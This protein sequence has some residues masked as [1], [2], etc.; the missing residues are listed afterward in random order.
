[1]IKHQIKGRNNKYIVELYWG[2]EGWLPK[3]SD[4][5]MH[6]IWTFMK[7]YNERFIQLVED[8]YGID[9]EN[10]PLETILRFYIDTGLFV[11]KGQ[12]NDYALRRMKV[13]AKHYRDEMTNE[14]YQIT[15][16]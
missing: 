1:M 12:I 10:D 15:G 8:Y 7:E 9:L 2:I 16:E 13:I 4:I 5:I 3:V 6:N 14:S 11:I